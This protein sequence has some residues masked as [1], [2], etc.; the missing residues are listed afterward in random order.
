MSDTGTNL[1]SLQ[2]VS[3]RYPIRRGFFQRVVGHVG[4][5]ERVSFDV[6]RGETLALVGESG[7][8]KSTLGRAILRLEDVA[9]GRISTSFG[10]RSSSR[11]DNARHAQVVFQDPLGSLD[12]RWT[13]GDL[14]GEGLDVH[15][16]ARGAERDARVRELLAQV[17]LPASA[18]FKFPHQLSGGQQQRVAIARALALRPELIVL[19]EATSALDV[20]VQAQILNLMKDLQAEYGLTYLFISHDL[21]VVGQFADRVAVMYLGR[22]M[23]I[24]RVEDV[25]IRPRHPYTKALLAASLKVD[26]EARIETI[27]LLRGDVPSPRN[28]PSGCRFRSRCPLAQPACAELVHHM[29]GKPDG[30]QTAA[31]LANDDNY[32]LSQGK[33]K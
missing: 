18:F 25:L 11:R 32:Q 14:I 8:G 28:P 30:R 10:G 4:A 1:L 29:A 24:G 7:C 15:R 12:P 5:V 23:E 9:E 33:T 16:I 19:D 13:V 26:P 21:T 20:S 2:D 3:V 27:A 22:I 31:C 17:E 6:K